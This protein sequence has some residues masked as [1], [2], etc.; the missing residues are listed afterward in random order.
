[1]FFSNVVRARRDYDIA[2]A[3][4]ATAD[5]I[6]MTRENIM[7]SART[8]M[9]VGRYSEEVIQRVFDEWPERSTTR[10]CS[11]MTL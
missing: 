11:V 5:D 2:S 6:T 10:G 7:A 4:R 1:V 9:P 8:L 3:C